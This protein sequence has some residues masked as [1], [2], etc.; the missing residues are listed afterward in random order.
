MFVEW[1]RQL[2]TSEDD[3]KIC[4][5]QPSVS[6]FPYCCINFPH[7]L[8]CQIST[9]QSIK[10]GRRAW[11]MH[12]FGYKSQKQL[13]QLNFCLRGQ[14]E[15]QILIMQLINATYFLCILKNWTWARDRLKTNNLSVNNFKEIL[16]LSGSGSKLTTNWS[17][18][19]LDF[20]L[21]A[22]E[23]ICNRTCVP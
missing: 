5:L 17:H 7:E 18:M 11:L 9:N 12:D 23:I 10:I 15:I 13:H 6:K 19:K 20:W 14:F 21:C 8:T 3:T 1:K 4:Q 2:K 16:D 22:Q